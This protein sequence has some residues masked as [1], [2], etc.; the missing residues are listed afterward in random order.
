VKEIEDKERGIELELEIEK[1]GTIVFLDM[2][3]RREKGKIYT[4][5]YQKDC[6]SGNYCHAKSD[7]DYSTKK[8]FINNMEDR[9]REVN[10]DK[11]KAE[12]GIDVF[13]EQLRKCGYDKRMLEY[14]RRRGREGG[15]ERK[16]KE[17]IEDEKKIWWGIESI[18]EETEVIKKMLKRMG[19]VHTYRKGSRKLL[20]VIRG[21]KRNVKREEEKKGDM[22][23]KGVI[24]RIQCKD[25][26]MCYVGETG[27]KLKERVKQHK[28]DVRLERDRNAIYKH[29]RDNGHSIDWKEVK[30]LGL[31]D[32]RTVRKWKEA[33]FIEVEGNKVMNWNSGL[34]I[35]YQWDKI[36]RSINS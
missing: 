17:K 29:I 24:Y 28:D 5:W 10:S 4:E 18:G 32:R 9:I 26:D 1:D 23:K 14:R 15:K 8:N 34:K 20:E 7:V 36:L 27:K 31:E 2:R 21:K 19:G 25:C 33:R 16:G 13:H 35:D 11:G 6:A 3:I 22:E 30:V 12:E